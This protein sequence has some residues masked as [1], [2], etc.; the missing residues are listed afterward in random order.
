[1]KYRGV[2]HSGGD[3]LQ[4][5]QMIQWHEMDAQRDGEQDRRGKYRVNL[6]KERSY[7][8]GMQLQRM[9]NG[10]VHLVKEVVCM[11]CS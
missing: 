3:A 7:S 8:D 1:M 10:C 11:Y 5:L 2:H 9:R 4:G 6:E